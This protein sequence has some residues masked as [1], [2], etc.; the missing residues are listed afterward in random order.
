[1]SNTFYHLTAKS[2][3]SKTG[4]IP[5]STTSAN[6]CP[7]E[8]PFI[9]GACYAKS[10]WHLHNH[11]KKV[12]DP[13]NSRGATLAEFA[14]QISALPAG[15]IWRHNQAGDLPGTASAIDAQ[16]LQVLIDAN[17]G[18][19]G[20]T[21][22][23][24]PTGLPSN[25]DA[26]RNANAQGFAVNLSANNIGQVD[27]L[28]ALNIGPV[29]TVLPAD[30]KQRVVTTDGGN[31]VVTCPA[32]LPNSRVQCAT[33]GGKKGPLCARIGRD[34]AIGF[35]AHGSPAG[36]QEANKLASEGAK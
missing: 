3:N 7:P 13:N 16:K 23:H 24:K 1:M 19:R 31:R 29:T 6:T 28:L 36:K 18:K 15:Q 10:G 21:Y 25:R 32:T 20:F 9:N 26:I 33:C 12:S 11:W 35:P 22:T 8:C 30:H 14:R 34:Y 4:P 5:V 17:K 27:E 2:S